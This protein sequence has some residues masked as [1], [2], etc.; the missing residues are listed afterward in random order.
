MGMLVYG[1]KTGV[2]D[3]YSFAFLTVSSTLEPS[4]V[5]GLAHSREILVSA[6]GRRTEDKATLALR[7]V[8]IPT[9]SG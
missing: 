9:A 2:G 7:A 3:L 8:I 5:Q 1:L 6:S 4:S